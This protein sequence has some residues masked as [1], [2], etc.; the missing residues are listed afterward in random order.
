MK[1]NSLQTI[2]LTSFFAFH[3]IKDFCQLPVLIWAATLVFAPPSSRKGSPP[4]TNR[5]MTIFVGSTLFYSSTNEP[6]PLIRLLGHRCKTLQF[7]TTL[8]GISKSIP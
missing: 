1:A 3:V 7:S 2:P 6:S 4:S 5:K 8:F